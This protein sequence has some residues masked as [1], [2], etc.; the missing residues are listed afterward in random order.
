M[1]AP[2]LIRCISPVPG[3][4]LGE[5]ASLDRRAFEELLR[6]HPGAFEELQIM[7]RGGLD[8]GADNRG[9]RPR[10]DQGLNVR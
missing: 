5:T 10:D 2:I 4:E 1:T 9:E 8:H 6:D 3:W 7:T